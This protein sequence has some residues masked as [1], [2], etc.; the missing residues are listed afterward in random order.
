MEGGVRSGVRP[1]GRRGAAASRCPAAMMR[2]GE[3]AKRSPAPAGDRGGVYCMVRHCD[4]RRDP[5]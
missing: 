3:T 2:G 4:P 1:G 5:I